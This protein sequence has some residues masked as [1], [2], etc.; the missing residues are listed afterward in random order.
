MSKPKVAVFSF[1]CCEGCGL[2]ILNCE[3]EL[4]DLVGAVDLVRW[5]E[6]MSETAE[7][8]DIAFCEGSVLQEKE[9]ERLQWIRGQAKVLVALGACATTGG[10]NMIRNFRPLAEAQEYVYGE[11]AK[12]LAKREFPWDSTAQVLPLDRVVKVD[13]YIHGCPIRREEFLAVTLAL[14]QGR[15]PVI[16]DYPVCVECKLAENVCVFDKGMTCLG[17]VTRAGCKAWC[18]SYGSP[19]DGCRGLIPNPN[20]NAEK[21]LLAERGLTVEDILR[22]FRLYCGYSEVSGAAVPAGAPEQRPAG[23]PPPTGPKR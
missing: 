1:A 7:E 11:K 2:Q 3:D 17:P 5:R 20:V 6:A 13:H 15:A 12:A 9:K 16:P 18:P 21:D 8:F 4:L 14:L 22:Q 19:C 23:G 10:L